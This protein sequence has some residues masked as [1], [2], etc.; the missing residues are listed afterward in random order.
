MINSSNNALLYGRTAATTRQFFRVV[1]KS[2]PVLGAT[3]FSSV[4]NGA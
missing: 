2:S 4:T 3:G 1:G